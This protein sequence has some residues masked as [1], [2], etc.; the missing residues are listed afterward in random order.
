MTDYDT[1]CI[2]LLHPRDVPGTIISRKPQPTR[3]SDYHKH[4]WE[5]QRN[6]VNDGRNSRNSDRSYT[7]KICKYFYK[8]IAKNDKA[9]KNTYAD[10]LGDLTTNSHV[11]FEDPCDGISCIDV[12]G[13]FHTEKDTLSEKTQKMTDEGVRN[14]TSISVDDNQSINNKALGKFS[15]YTKDRMVIPA[16]CDMHVDINVPKGIR[17]YAGLVMKS[18]KMIQMT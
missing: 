3:M 9:I 13:K 12:K 6:N 8:D 17:K 2:P 5:L 16:Q 7:S 14:L 18:V 1:V 4:M 11:S 15:W 10:S